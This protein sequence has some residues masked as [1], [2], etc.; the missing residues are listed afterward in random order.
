MNDVG[1]LA[2]RTSALR[3][4]PSTTPRGRR[5]ALLAALLAPA[6]AAGA[7]LLFGLPYRSYLFDLVGGPTDWRLITKAP[8]ERGIVCGVVSGTGSATVVK[9]T[10]V[11]AAQYAASTNGRGLE[12]VGLATTGSL[13]ELSWETAD[14]RVRLLVRRP[15]SPRMTASISSELEPEGDG[16]EELG[17]RARRRAAESAEWQTI[18]DALRVVLDAVAGRHPDGEVVTAPAGRL[19]SSRS[20][21][22]NSVLASNRRARR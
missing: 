1:G 18:D 21:G 17:L 7:E 13:A 22:P 8:M 10:L 15:G 12:R 19:P 6:E 5:D 2:H 11:W 16:D 3:G 20:P 9:E 4:R 14:R